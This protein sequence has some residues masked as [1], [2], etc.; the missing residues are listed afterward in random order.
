M[1]KIV[2]LLLAL[3]MCLSLCACGTKVIDTNGK[4]LNTLYRGE[5]IIL[6]EDWDYS[7]RTV[8]HADTKVVYF[9][10]GGH[11]GYL[12]PYQIYQDGVIYGAVY[13]NGEIVPIPY[14]MGI[15]WDMLSLASK[16]LN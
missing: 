12:T 4:E 7:H 8:Y 1:K 3:V 13:E 6:E 9:H 15:T 11:G 14:A 10:Q 2:C 5:F 16:Y